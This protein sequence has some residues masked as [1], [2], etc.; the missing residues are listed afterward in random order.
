MR[1]RQ[2]QDKD[3]FFLQEILLSYGTEFKDHKFDIHTTYVLGDRDAF[4]TYYIDNGTPHLIHFAI[5]LSRRSNELAR[6]LIKTF[7]GC[8]LS[9]GYTKAILHSRKSYLNRFI[10]YY[11]KVKPYAVEN[12]YTFYLVEV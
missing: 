8:L 2:Y 4:F 5:K 9:S 3:Y 11:F 6:L 12:G 7:Q 1:I 10:E